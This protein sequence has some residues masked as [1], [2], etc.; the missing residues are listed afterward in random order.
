[1][2][3]RQSGAVRADEAELLNPKDVRATS[4][5]RLAKAAGAGLAAWLLTAVPEFEMSALGQGAAR[6]AGL[7]GGSEV[8]AAEGGWALTLG[9]MPVL[10]TRACSGADFFL[11]TAVLIGWRT[12]GWL[13]AV[14]GGFAIA[15]VVNAARIT[16]VAQAHRWVISRV[17]EAY[18]AFLHMLVGVA[19]FLPALIA[20]NLACETYARR[21]S[22]PPACAAR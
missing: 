15:M 13:R 12:G 18:G 19:V 1:M 20:L 4:R 3:R 10:V 9:G 7:L 21:C 14:G 16:V 2:Q 6:L 8:E 22:N 11:L 17:P 5:R